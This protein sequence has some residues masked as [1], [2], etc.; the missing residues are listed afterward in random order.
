MLERTTASGRPPPTQG[1]LTIALMPS[2][3][4]APVPSRSMLRWHYCC[5]ALAPGLLPLCCPRGGKRVP[6]SAQDPS[7]LPSRFSCTMHTLCPSPLLLSP[8]FLALPARCRLGSQLQT[9]TFLGSILI[10]G[11]L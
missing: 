6:P 7:E 3:G 5:S 10:L 9:S 8:S 2:P 4:S 11:C 1:S